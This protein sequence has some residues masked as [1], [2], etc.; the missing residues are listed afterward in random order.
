MLL[1]HHSETC[2]FNAQVIMSAFIPWPSRYS[3]DTHGGEIN[4]MNHGYMSCNT[5]ASE[6]RNL[7]SFF[8]LGNDDGAC[9]IS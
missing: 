4:I 1:Y 2:S 7:K 8:P 6:K 9:N 3:C 5:F